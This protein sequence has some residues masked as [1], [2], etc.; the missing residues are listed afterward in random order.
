MYLVEVVKLDPCNGSTNT[1]G[2]GL[3]SI[4][5]KVRHRED[6]GGLFTISCLEV[7][8]WWEQYC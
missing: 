5:H 4:S 8:T 6:L 1:R 2:D 7:P 3:A